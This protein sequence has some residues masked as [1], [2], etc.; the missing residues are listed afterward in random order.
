MLRTKDKEAIRAGTHRDLVLLIKEY[1]RQGHGLH[2]GGTDGDFEG[3]WR[4]CFR[5]TEAA[6]VTPTKQ[7]AYRAPV[8]F[9]DAPASTRA[10][11]PAAR[12]RPAGEP[13]P[14][15]APLRKPEGYGNRRGC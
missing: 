6:S 7:Y 12:T 5:D 10:N 9:P 1:A 13:L 15:T 4:G 8:T 14:K 11:P 3:L 2:R